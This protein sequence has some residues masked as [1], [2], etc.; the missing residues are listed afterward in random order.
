MDQEPLQLAEG[1]VLIRDRAVPDPDGRRALLRRQLAAVLGR[2]PEDLR[3][4]ADGRGRPFLL[5]PDDHMYFSAAHRG[6]LLLVATSRDRPV[7]ADLELLEPGLLEPSRGDVARS[8]FAPS[9]AD[10]LDGL[11]GRARA[12]GF[13]RLW[14]AKEAVLKARGLGIG[15]GLLEPDL[16]PVLP[17]PGPWPRSAIVA[18]GG[19][20]FGLDWFPVALPGAEGWAARATRL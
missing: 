7:G 18:A 11:A 8:C 14:T 5:P 16:T 19:E 10:W 15:G 20:R 12:D 6:D 13:L 3:L 4:A 1:L 17:G 9:E 2:A